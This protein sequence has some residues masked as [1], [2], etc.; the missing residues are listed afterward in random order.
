MN[1][2]FFITYIL[3]LL[4]PAVLGALVMPIMQLFK[5]LSTKLDEAPAWLKQLI[6]AG[7]ALGATQLAKLIGVP[8]P[9][10]ILSMNGDA[11]TAV[12]TALVAFLVHKLAKSPA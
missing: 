5:K 3:P 8:V 4:I 7:M 10:D 6:V 12:L 9:A 11:V 2:S 1:M